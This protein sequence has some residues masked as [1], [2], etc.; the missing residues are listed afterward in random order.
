MTSG[1]WQLA[2]QSNSI[3]RKPA[4][5]ALVQVFLRKLVRGVFTFPVDGEYPPAAPV[6]QELKTVDAASERLIRLGVARL[7]GAP[8]VSYV[9]PLFG[10][11]RHR[12]FKEAL[13]GE[14]V[15]AAAHIL[16]G[17]KNPGGDVALVVAAA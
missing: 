7:V 4:K 9:V 17:G 10:T 13:A 1:K 12:R 16:I 3:R 11:I 2:W 8:D 6:K 5:A 14:G 15:F